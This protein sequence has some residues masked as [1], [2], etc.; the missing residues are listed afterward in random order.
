MGSKDTKHNNKENTHTKIKEK[1]AKR[2]KK[3]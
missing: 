3:R 2:D 1:K